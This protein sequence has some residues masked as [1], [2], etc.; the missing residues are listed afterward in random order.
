[1][2]EELSWWGD[3]NENAR[4]EMLKDLSDSTFLNNAILSIFMKSPAEGQ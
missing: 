1:M 2:L 3:E 4:Q